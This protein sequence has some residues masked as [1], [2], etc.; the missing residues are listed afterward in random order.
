MKIPV[1]IELLKKYDRPGPR[2]T[3]YP[4]APYF[5]EEIGTETFLKHIRQDDKAGGTQPL[6]LYFH[7]PFCDTLCYFC[8]CNMMVT[9][10]RQ[11]IENY[12]DYLEKEIQL[13]RPHINSARKVAQLHWGGGTPTHLSP[14]QIKR[15]GEIIHHYFDFTDNAEVS[16]ELD[17]RELTRR[18][19]EALADV[20]FN[21]CSMGVQDFNPQV[22]KAVNRIQPENITR[23]VVLWA[24]EL[25]F[26]S[27][28]IDLM[29]GLPFQ[30]STTFSQTIDTILDIDPNRLAVFNY[31]HL[32]EMIKH[33]R[34]IKNE[35]LPTAEEKLQLLKLSIEKLT[36]AGYEYIGMDHF[37][38]PDDELTLAMKQGT[39]YRNFQGYSTHSGLNLFALGISSISMLSD[40][41]VQNYKKLDDYYQA[42]DEGRLPVVRGVQLNEDDRLRREVITELMCN[43]RLEKKKIEEKYSISF[44][45]YFAYA[46]SQL[47]SFQDDGL[48]V[49]HAERLTVTTPGRL[50]IRNIAM[51]FDA[52]LQKKE[53]NKPQ[54]SRTV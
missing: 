6:S 53:N 22:Q 48:I 29:Y 35:W 13:L 42:I 26:N 38:K 8:G 50:L 32:P 18:H 34:L 23:Q 46:L 31:A 14:E 25:G 54:F 27:V 21:R 15:L 30:K 17:P 33:Q 47:E 5:H 40:L 1:D 51:N 20:G 28:N 16:V 12:I 45:E 9:R 37:A 7:L 52:Y 36:G 24:R 3:S 49:L 41:Y 44:D 11:K 43:F 19:M 4:T 10:N 2:Y 39:L